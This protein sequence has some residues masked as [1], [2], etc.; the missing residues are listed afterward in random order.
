MCRKPALYK[1]C[2]LRNPY[3]R[4]KSV[5]QEAAAPS[6]SSSCIPAGTAHHHCM[7]LAPPCLPLISPQLPNCILQDFNF[8]WAFSA[9][10]WFPDDSLFLVD[11]HVS[12]CSSLQPWLHVLTTTRGELGGHCGMAKN[13]L[14]SLHEHSPLCQREQWDGQSLWNDKL[15]IIVLMS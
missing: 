1:H 8:Y 9:V 11:L 3:M 12:G 13:P 2:T 15:V 5:L 6:A 14:C 7:L 10:S 4:T